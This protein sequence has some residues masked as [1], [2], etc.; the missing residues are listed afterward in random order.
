MLVSFVAA[1]ALC[2]GE[3]ADYDH[4]VGAA[5]RA[6]GF[7][8][9]QQNE[10]GTFGKSPSAKMPGL[11]GLALKGIAG[12]SYKPRMEHPVVARA[13]KFLLSKQQPNGSIADPKFGLENYN[14][15][16][17]VIALLAL[18]DSS[19]KAVLD[20]AKKF[21]LTCQLDEELGYKPDEHPRAFGGFGY[22]SSK[23]A[24]VSN[25]GFSL[26][27]LNALGLEKNSKAYQNAI[28]FLKRSQDNDETNDV[29]E[30]NGGDNSGAF[31]YLPSD[32]EFGKV[33][34][35]TGK[36]MPKPYGN[37]T[38]MAVKSLIYAG[39]KMDDAPMQAAWKWIKNNYSADKQPGGD[40][41][42]GYFYYAN[43]FAK[44]FTAAGIKELE[45]ADGKKVNWAKDLSEHLIKLQKPDGSFSNDAA[46]WMENDPILAT[47][48][49]LD[50]LNLCTEALR[51]K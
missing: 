41:N 32:S 15:S 39:M 38:Y 21:I 27:A 18:E 8:I 26:E 11:V 9:G 7:L 1:G 13:V 6:T 51:T 43:V 29:A 20:K 33:K 14:T 3:S 31:V 47:S 24:D 35:R 2:A 30:M 5:N 46:R 48:Y 19:F 10:D 50:A 23:R 28:L 4:V 42:Q 22:G 49:A 17:A 16:V 34:T 12:C 44:T 40:G 37:M 36:M 25:T 45:L